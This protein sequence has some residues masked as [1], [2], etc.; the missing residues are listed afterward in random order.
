MSNPKINSQTF[1]LKD[2]SHVVNGTNFRVCSIL[3]F[4]KSQSCSEDSSQSRSEAVAKRPQ[5][6]YH[7]G[8]IVAKSKS[9]R[10][11]VSRSRAGL[12]T[13]PSSTVSSSPENLR[14]TDHEMRCEADTG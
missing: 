11:L 14:P 2:I 12:S 6:G 10:N 9:V 5:E 13:V 4:F 3:P 1:D 8:R 7:D